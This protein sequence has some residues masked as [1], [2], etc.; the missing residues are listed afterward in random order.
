MALLGVYMGLGLIVGL[1]AGMLGV[2]GGSIIVP[3]LLFL[4]ERNHVA[5]PV[6]I[7][8]A[9][10]TSLASILFTSLAAVRAQHKRRAID[11]PLATTLAGAAFLGSFAGA[12]AAGFLPGALLKEIF[13]VFLGFVAW[14]LMSGWRPKAWRGLPSRPVLWAVGGCIGAVSA[15]LGI[16][17]GSMTI[18]F[19]SACEVDL[20]RAIAVSTVLGFPIALFGT[21]GFVLAGQRQVSL[22]AESLGYVYLPALIGLTSV[23]LAAVPLGV[24]LAHRL[25]VVGLRRILGA[26]LVVV[27]IQMTLFR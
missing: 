24:R 26:L 21:A 25:P 7:K 12:Y 11:W 22:P 10:G 13:G 23:S 1:L 9:I 2:G 17:G 5:A 3:A 15:L 18:P 14:Q 19:L 27:A 16:G 20:R 4:F 8:L 6:A